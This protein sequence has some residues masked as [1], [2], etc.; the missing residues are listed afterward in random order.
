MKL[1]PLSK[2]GKN[3]GKYFAMVDDEDFDLLNQWNW[4][5][6]IHCGIPYAFRNTDKSKCGSTKMSMHRQIV[7]VTDPAV[8]VD[9]KNRNGLD[10]TRGNIR[11][12]TRSENN[13]NRKSTG[14]SKYLGAYYNKGS[15]H[16][17]LANGH[18]KTY[19]WGSW[20]SS[21]KVNGKDLKLGY[22]K[23]EE[24]AARAYDEAAKKYHGE[25]ANLNFKQQAA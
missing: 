18:P 20:M 25:F 4:H 23:T 5:V 6:A 12:C 3:K 10:N 14:R 24:A 22:F 13:R 19:R 7:G 11:T 21:I 1:I 17:I 15:K 16:V 8:L 2:T 9:H